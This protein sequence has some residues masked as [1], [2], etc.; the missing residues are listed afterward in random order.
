MWKK[1]EE[2]KMMN[3]SRRHLSIWDVWSL[4]PGHGLS[5]FVLFSPLVTANI[6]PASLS[7]SLVVSENELNHTIEY[8]IHID[9]GIGTTDYQTNIISIT[10]RKTFLLFGIFFESNYLR[11]YI[12]KNNVASDLF[13]MMMNTQN[14]SYIS[15]S[16]CLN[17][18]T[19]SNNPHCQI[20][21][22]ITLHEIIFLFF[23]AVAFSYYNEINILLL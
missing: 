6:K 9:T 4:C 20:F 7:I 3:P 12:T 22:R 13:L 16:C 5:V 11:E 1:E 8:N 10:Y 18:I 23:C 14:I 2:K 21:I 19:F 17:F 15:F